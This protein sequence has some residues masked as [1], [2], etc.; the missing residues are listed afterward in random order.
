MLLHLTAF[1]VLEE[2]PQQLPEGVGTVLELYFL[3]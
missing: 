3:R 2:I 1:A